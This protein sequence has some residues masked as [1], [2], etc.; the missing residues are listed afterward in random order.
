LSKPKARSIHQIRAAPHTKEVIVKYGPRAFADTI[1]RHDGGKLIRRWHRSVGSLLGTVGE[2][3]EQV[4]VDRTRDVTLGVVLAPT[5]RLDFDLLPVI[6]QVLRAVGDPEIG[7]VE[8]VGEPVGFDKVVAIDEAHGSPPL[9]GSSGR[10][11]LQ[12][13][14]LDRA[15][16][17]R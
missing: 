5:D 3:D 13:A 11:Q 7:I 14:V 4:H 15:D 16:S 8:M 6:W 9:A 1:P 17:G 12:A 2:L 10:D